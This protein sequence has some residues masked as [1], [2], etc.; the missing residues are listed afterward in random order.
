MSLVG[1]IHGL[2]SPKLVGFDFNQI[3]VGVILFDLVVQGIK[4]SK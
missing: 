3:I 1:K 2:S 4:A